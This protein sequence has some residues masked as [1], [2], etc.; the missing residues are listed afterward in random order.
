MALAGVTF[1]TDRRIPTRNIQ[2]LNGVAHLHHAFRQHP[3]KDA[4][5]GHDAVAHQLPDG[6]ALVAGLADLGDFQEH[7]V[8]HPQARAHRQVHHFQAVHRQVFSEIA[9]LHL[10]AHGHHLV[11]AG[12]GQQAHLAD[13]AF[14]MGIALQAVFH[15]ETGL[16]DVVLDHALA[17]ADGDGM[18][19]AQCG[20]CG[21]FGS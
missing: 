7:V 13:A 2:H 18:D 4:F 15:Q 16:R 12:E 19:A 17:V 21:N 3:G 1:I 14:G 20:W 8:S 5:P 9:G 10:G 11:D 6:A